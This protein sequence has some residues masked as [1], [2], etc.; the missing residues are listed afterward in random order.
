MS[1]PMRDRIT[2]ALKDAMKSKDATRVGTLRLV[3]AT[4]KDREIAARQ[5]EGEGPVDADAELMA[6]LAKMVRQRED[7]IGA[8]EQAGR[9]EL[10]AREQAEIDIIREFLPKPMTAEEV[11]AAVA[12]AIAE[13]EAS[14]IRDMGRVIGALKARH[15]GRMDFG[16]VGQKVKAALA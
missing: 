1:E 9:L 13:T 7:S 11:E 10:A 15:P 3:V 16:A 12:E 8:Y 14:S 6:I 4:I 2:T 5:S